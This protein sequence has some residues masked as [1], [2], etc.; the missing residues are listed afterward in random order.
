MRE[1]IEQLTFHH[2]KKGFFLLNSISDKHGLRELWLK[3][4][5]KLDLTVTF[6]SRS[7]VIG[8]GGYNY[9][10]NTPTLKF[11]MGI[12]EVEQNGK[13]MEFPEYKFLRS[14]E[15][16]GSCRGDLSTVVAA[17]VAHECS[18]VFQFWVVKVRRHL[19]MPDNELLFG[20]NLK[21]TLDSHG[22][23]WKYIYA[24]LRTTWINRLPSWEYMP[25][26]E[27]KF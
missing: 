20:Y 6:K 26:N 15:D 19:E 25:P 4:L 8:R 2:V 21:D 16:I 23:L 1:T 24:I 14:R 17:L 22:E 3:E 9:T 5:K 7:N 10:A 13:K 11:S 18:H 27:H 12:F